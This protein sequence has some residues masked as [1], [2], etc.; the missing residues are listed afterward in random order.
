VIAAFDIVQFAAGVAVGG[1][2]VAL[3]VFLGWALAGTRR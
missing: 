3:G 2:G 1:A